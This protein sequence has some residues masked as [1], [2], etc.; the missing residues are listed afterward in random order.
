LIIR[1]NIGVEAKAEAAEDEVFV[2]GCGAIAASRARSFVTT[3][4]VRTDEIIVAFW[5]TSSWAVVVKA[6]KVMLVQERPTWMFSKCELLHF[7]FNSYGEVAL[8]WCTVIEITV[9]VRV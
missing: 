8:R 9:H 6:G 5:A 7:S 4:D 1:C 2:P 3:D